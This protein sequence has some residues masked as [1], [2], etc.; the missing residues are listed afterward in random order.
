MPIISQVGARSL[1]VRLIYSSIFIILALGAVSMIY[2]ML[3]MASQSI[4][5]QVD[6]PRLSVLPEFLWD[7]GLLWGK[8][9][10]SKYGNMENVE[11][12]WRQSIGDWRIIKPPERI[13]PLAR[14]FIDYRSSFQWPREWATVGHAETRQVVSKNGRRYR[15]MLRQAAG[16]DIQSVNKATNIFFSSWTEVSLPAA[17]FWSRRFGFPQTLDY[18]VLY[19]M[20]ATSP[21]ADWIIIDPDGTFLY[22]YLRPQWGDIQAYNAAHQTSYTHYSQVL[23]DTHPPK[24]PSQRADWENYVR[25]QLNLA[26]IRIDPKTAPAWRQFLSERYDGKIQNLN[27]VW[28]T[29]WTNFDSIPLP[30]GLPDKPSVQTD[31]GAFLKNAQACPLDSLSIY[32]PRQGFEQ[33]IAKTKNVD[34]SQVAPLPI[35]TE[36]IDYLDFQQQKGPLRW[37]FVKRN[38]LAV[39]DYLLLHGNGIRNTVI[40]C[41][42]M[43][44]TNLLVNPLAAYALSRYK[45]PSTYTILLFCMATMAFPAEVTMIPSFLL[46]KRFPLYGLLVGT[47]ATLLAGWLINR[48]RPKWPSL[49][50]G[51]LAV[52]AGIILGWW[53]TPLVARELFGRDDGTISLLNTFWALVLPGM[54]NG[55]SIFLL[56]GFFDSLPKELYEASDIDGAGEWTKFWMITMSLSKPIL[57]VLALAAFTTAYSEFMMALVIIPDQDMW[58]IMVWLYQL[59]SNSH[60]TLIYASL[61]IAAIPTLIIFLFCQNL[62]IR[63]IVVPSEK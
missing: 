34:L 51:M 38:Y 42:L 61:V 23:L 13:D 8:Y 3:L 29:Q 58:T 5:S 57:A 21:P 4:Q 46:L 11:R 41:F 48:L 39:M 62:I 50:T 47:V 17:L 54:A 35:P 37:E 2:P 59:Q 10:Q 49:V 31:L 24:Q 55:Y 27:L 30:V 28:Q 9:A 40:F 15:D 63:G 52:V 32:G 56:K 12:F 25:S 7:D 18:Q 1:K 53:L 36:S 6:Y 19:K 16:D 14:A 43:V 20:T 26:F 44:M 45:P 60:P 33:Y 22:D